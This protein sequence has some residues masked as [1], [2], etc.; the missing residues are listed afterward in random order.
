MKNGLRIGLLLAGCLVSFSAFAVIAKPGSGVYGDEHYHYRK[1]F[2]GNIYAPV[3]ER[4]VP[5]DLPQIQTTFPT[6]GDIRSLII[7]VNYADVSF[8]IPDPQQ[9]F[10]RM[11]NEEGYSENGGT[12]SARDYFL[13]N[14]FGNFRPTFD[15]YGPVTLPRKRA[16][17][18]GGDGQAT[19]YSEMVIDACDLLQDEIDWSKYDI[20]EDG[21]IDNIF[22]YF[23]GHNEA[24]GGPEESVWPHRAYVY[25]N[26]DGASI[27]YYY[28][29]ADGKKYW[30]W[31]YACTSELTDYQGARMC[32][33]GTFCH[34]FSHVL[35]LD[36][37]YD[38]SDGEHYTVG[39]WDI[40]SQGNYNNDGRTPPSYSAFER[41]WL[42]WLTPEELTEAQDLLLEPLNTSNK[43]Y[44][45]AAS[46][47]NLNGT[48]P[49]PKEYWMIE[50]RQRVGWDAPDGCL[51][52]TGLLITHITWNQS[53]WNNN[54]PCNYLPMVYD[55][56]EAW[57]QNPYMSTG[58]DTYPGQFRVT[59]FCPV[60][61]DGDSLLSHSLQN[62]RVAGD[63]N[64][65][66]HHGPYTGAGLTITPENPPLLRT[67]LSEGQEPI[68]A[69]VTL[70]V[71]GSQL[72]D[73]LLYI[74]INTKEFELSLDSATWTHD[75]LT[76]A[77]AADSTY[78]APL[79]V[80]YIPSEACQSHYAT[81]FVQTTNNQQFTQT[82]LH[83]E[84]ARAT[85]ITPVQA[86]AASDITPYSFTARWEEQSDAEQYR[87]A[88]YSVSQE[89]SETEVQPQLRMAQPKAAYTTAFSPVPIRT[90]QTAITMS[91]G[92]GKDKYRAY[93][94]TDA[95]NTENE[96]E[97]VDSFAIR[98]INTT[99]EHEYTFPT[100][101]DYRQIRVT[102]DTL[103]GSHF[104]T[105]SRLKYTC[106]EK[107]EYLYADT[108]LR[109]NAPLTE[110]TVTGLQP[111][112]NYY[113]YLLC[114]EHKGC[115]LHISDMGTTMLTRT[116]AGITQ[117]SKQFTIYQKDGKISAYLPSPAEK[118]SLLKVFTTAGTLLYTLSLQ[119]GDNAADIPSTVLTK[120]QLYLVKYCLNGE[121]KRKGLWAKFIY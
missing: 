27:R 121:V 21:E 24:E 102:Y 104:A 74:S 97:R 101:K 35:G 46:K 57:Y 67:V 105:L 44:L 63:V 15:V 119:E 95:L 98:A 18:G 96:W 3:Q 80:R 116:L 10:S 103:A 16:Y 69:A 114:Q 17:Y 113:Y 83:G 37:L 13:A 30:L 32:G 106:T 53:R 49:N 68:P 111:A 72:Q 65:A 62:I 100:E 61:N 75:T 47:H 81:L 88:V 25:T 76:V 87:L 45:M 20:N 36:D 82:M 94:L 59:S 86:L 19:H 52:G 4:L 2:Q 70:S 79:Y 9:A 41:F 31:D 78:S 93:I 8:V 108:T 92:N 99:I 120:G 71:K 28:Q 54:T 26:E 50:N 51:P 115:E 38:T 73:T 77:V 85:L 12:G 42:G 56:C 58:T 14:S 5:R 22:I 89:K 48:N 109:L 40:M 112:T 66:F 64:I 11:L 107:A 84:S 118:N 29:G 117:T 23:A 1:D 110:Y 90:L 6:Q 55:I 7:L 39:Q 34:E 33:I 43:A 60:S 91:Y